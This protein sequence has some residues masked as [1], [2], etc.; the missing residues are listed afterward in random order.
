MAAHPAL[1]YVGPRLAAERHRRNLTL[2]QLATSSGISKAHLSRLESGERQPSL[3]VL[4]DLAA[5][6]AVPVSVLLGEEHDGKAILVTD[7][8]AAGRQV[9]GLRVISR[10]GFP[11]SSV[12]DAL[13]IT[14]EADRP[15]SAPV[16]HEG[17]EWLYVVSGALHL[18]YDGAIHELGEGMSA[19]FDADRLHRLSAT[20]GPARVLMVSGHHDAQ[21]HLIHR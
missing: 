17:E 9:N 3:A 6:L 5:A 16:R 7:G 19:H 18:E 20:G 2:E 8:S 11:A 13:E 4:L 12:L 21:L 1:D 14:V 15:A 10:S